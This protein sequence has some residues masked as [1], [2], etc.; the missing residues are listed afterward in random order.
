[1]GLSLNQ[2][3]VLLALI[4][5]VPAR[6]GRATIRRRIQAAAG[7]AGRVLKRLEARCQALVLV[8]GL[9]AIVVHRRP[10][11]VG[12]EPASRVWFLGQKADARTGATWS[13]A[14]H[15]GTALSDVLADAGTGRHA[16]IAAVPQQRRKDEQPPLE[17]GLDVFPT[18]QEARRVWRLSWNRVDRLWEQAEAASR[19]VAP[20]QRQG[21]DARGVAVAA[22]AAWTKAEAASPSRRDARS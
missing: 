13:K 11:L 19:R 6:P 21:R 1:M 20:A 9:D 22:R 3:L 5:G 2:I 15:D 7:A 16:G 12:V 4:M 10:V 8:G 18:T 17:K 14:W